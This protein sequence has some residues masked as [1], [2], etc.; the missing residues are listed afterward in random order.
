VNIDEQPA[1][2]DDGYQ[3][4]FDEATA[5]IDSGALAPEKAEPEAGA[6]AATSETAPA[7]EAAAADPWANASPEI[8]AERDR[9]Q[10][11]ADKLKRSNASYRGRA[12]HLQRKVAELSRLEAAQ[13]ANGTDPIAQ[14]KQE[15]P[16]F[17]TTIEA[18]LKP[19][20][21]QMD[22]IRQAQTADSQAAQDELMQIGVQH[23]LERHPDALTLK[24]DPNFI[25]WVNS[26]PKAVQALSDSDD[27]DEV[28]WL[29]DRFKLE[30][31]AAIQAQ[32]GLQPQGQPQPDARRQRQI[33]AGRQVPSGRTPASSAVAPDDYDG[34]YAQHLASL[35][36][37]Q[38]IR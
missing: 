25:G 21:A 24:D 15:Y 22:A 8:I 6:D 29:F 27:A 19:V 32:Q 26:Q 5:R 7:A 28:S 11:E 20:Q 9:L 33:D 36:R 12:S 4:A 31:N 37:R 34:A 14:L 18:A 30:R 16:D 23:L 10:A 2:G 17:G 13:Q 1:E 35:K 38:A 3:K